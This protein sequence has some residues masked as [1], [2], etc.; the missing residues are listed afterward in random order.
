MSKAPLGTVI[1]E[2]GTR[3]GALAALQAIAA[4][5]PAALPGEPR[6]L[7]SSHASEYV[8]SLASAG[9]FFAYLARADL[10]DGA[11]EGTSTSDELLEAAIRLT[12]EIDDVRPSLYG[13]VAGLG[14]TIHHVGRLA[15]DRDP[16][17][18]EV[19]DA[20]LLAYLE[21]LDP[22][23]SAF[24]L[25]GGLIGLGIYG[26]EAGNRRLV[27]LVAECL[28]AAAEA[29]ADGV[30]WWT[31]PEIGGRA[32]YS[33]GHFNLGLAHGVAGALAFLADV[34][35]TGIADTRRLLEGAA[36]W[37]LG[38]RLPEG[39]SRTFPWA[40][41]PDHPPL[42]WAFDPGWAYSDAGIAFAL[43]RA[44]QVLED[45]EATAEALA[46]AEREARELA[47]V[48]IRNPGIGYGPAGH[49]RIFTR[50]FEH[51]GRQ[52]FRGA[53]QQ[54]LDD[55]LALRQPGKGIGG[56]VTVDRSGRERGV[57]PSFLSGASGIGLVLL[58]A[59]SSVE[60]LWDRL[61]L[62]SPPV[63]RSRTS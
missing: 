24:D 62:L 13:G 22:T 43:F 20:E 3:S 45:T 11:H 15:G 34:H 47:S 29:G 17:A 63:I 57:D 49:V 26:L 1:L 10:V 30:T 46:V 32:F 52:V 31:P 53:A 8:W 40:V 7:P 25:M 12:E 6:D 19:L 38:Q 2:G 28:E 41:A 33:S 56:F 51:T 21:N 58:A 36:R 44:G 60:P 27:E 37:L 4:E 9:L 14:W 5:L 39:E 61:L 48:P 59:C 35:D 50:W 55:L 18:T 54:S 23:T 42:A 16:A